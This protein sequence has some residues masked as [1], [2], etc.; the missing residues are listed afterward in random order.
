MDRKSTKF[1]FDLYKQKSLWSWNSLVLLCCLNSCLE[2]Q[3][4]GPLKIQLQ[5]HLGGNTLQAWDKAL[6]KAVCALNQCPV[7]VAFPPIGRIHDP[8]NQGVEMG[9]AS[10]TI[11]PSDPLAEFL[12]SSLMMSCSAGLHSVSLRGRNASTSTHTNNFTELDVK[13]ATWPLWAPHA[14]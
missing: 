8:R 14:S 12:P 6:Q 7:Y 10:L 13:T 4:N 11:T 3:W 9:V 1:L 5:C 2:R